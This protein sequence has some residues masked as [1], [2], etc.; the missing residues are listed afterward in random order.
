[1]HVNEGSGYSKQANAANET[2]MTIRP[3]P[4]DAAIKDDDEVIVYTLNVKVKLCFFFSV[5]SCS[6][7]S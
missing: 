6:Y 4:G 7:S 1:M 2:S 3:A 5:L